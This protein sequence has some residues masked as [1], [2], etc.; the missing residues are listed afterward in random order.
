MS[1]GGVEEPAGG[2]DGILVRLLEVGVSAVDAVALYKQALE[3]ERTRID[4][5][6]RVVRAEEVRAKSESRR[7]ASTTEVFTRIG[8]QEREIEVIQSKLDVLRKT[9][10]LHVGNIRQAIE[11][12]INEVSRMAESLERADQRNYDLLVFALQIRMGGKGK[13]DEEQQR[14]IRELM[15][16][17][18]PEV[19]DI[20]KTLKARMRSTGKRLMAL[21]QQQASY[22]AIDSPVHL[23]AQI[24]EASS[25]MEE[26]RATIK[27]LEE[28]REQE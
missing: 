5:L 6:G 23:V 19:E 18:G 21:Q 3:A 2:L 4:L 1:E 12:L 11:E 26:L 7:A 25:D 13:V 8:H 27:A 10:E 24:D 17:E 20:I 16:L 22:G 28:D 9:V 15:H 14:G